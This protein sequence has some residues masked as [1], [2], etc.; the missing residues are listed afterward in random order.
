MGCFAEKISLIP[1]FAGMRGKFLAV[2]LALATLPA[3]ACFLN[4]Q[5]LGTHAKIRAFTMPQY[6]EKDNRLQFIVYGK[7]ADNKGAM[8]YLDDLVIDFIRNDLSDINDVKMLP[9]VLP[10]PL[11]TPSKDIHAF[12]SDKD[13]SQGLVFSDAAVLDKNTRMLRSDQKVK[14]RSTFLDVDGVGFDADQSRK[15]LHIRSNVKLM[16]R[17]VARKQTPGESCG[18]RRMTTEDFHEQEIRQQPVS[19]H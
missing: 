18:P 3:P 9:D 2:L 1:V 6:Q 13:H 14:F 15:F 12:W 8:L 4:A 10:Y 17:P 19:K 5:E 11:D 16:I 7:K